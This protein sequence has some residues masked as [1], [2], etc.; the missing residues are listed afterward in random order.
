M[1]ILFCMGGVV[2][3]SALY[4]LVGYANR[5][6][7]EPR[8]MS[9]AAFAA[10]TLLSFAAAQMPGS[11]HYPAGVVWIGS[12]IGIGAGFG[13]LGITMAVASKLPVTVVNTVVS[14]SLALPILLSLVLYK[15]VPS[16]R[17]SCGL[18]F[19]AASIVLIQKE[20]R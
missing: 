19:A 2:C 7:A 14:L 3:F 8:G 15:E 20:S 9:F 11:A 1:G 18:A 5:R 10:G 16:T 17:K 6:G 13:L 4:L 12:A